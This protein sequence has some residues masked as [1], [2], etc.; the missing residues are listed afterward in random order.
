M[1]WAKNTNHVLN[2]SDRLKASRYLFLLPIIPSINLQLSEKLNS[3][4]SNIVKPK[5]PALLLSD[6]NL[7]KC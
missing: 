1:K 2:G 3:R 6:F 4:H 7:I 5:P